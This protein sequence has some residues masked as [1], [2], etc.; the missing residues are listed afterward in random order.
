M[1]TQMTLD[2]YKMRV[3]D[4]L[5][6]WSPQTTEEYLNKIVYGPMIPNEIWEQY[7]KD[8]SPEDLPAAW[9][10]GA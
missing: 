5:R 9:E 4:S 1:N 10:A 3:L 7:M 6:R 8:F 2:E